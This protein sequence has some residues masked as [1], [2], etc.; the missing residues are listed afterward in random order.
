MGEPVCAKKGF[1]D[2]EVEKGKTYFWCSCGRSE[3]QPFCD[4]AHT[5]TGLQALAWTADESKTV[6]FCGCKRTKTPLLCDGSHGKL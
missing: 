1:Y 6:F 5:G 3:K 2:V 4:G